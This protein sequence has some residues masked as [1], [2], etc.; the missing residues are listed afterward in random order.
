MVMVPKG[1]LEVARES[2]LLAS[3]VG[4][5]YFLFVSAVFT[6]SMIVWMSSNFLTAYLEVFAQSTYQKLR[7]VSLAIT[8]SSERSP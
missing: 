7:R 6:S 3:Q 8:L 5:K 4:L 2:D 1:P